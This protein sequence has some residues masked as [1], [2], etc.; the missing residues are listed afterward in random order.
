MLGFTGQRPRCGEITPDRIEYMA[1][2]LSEERPLVPHLV[3]GLSMGGMIG[4]EWGAVAHTGSK[5]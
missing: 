4:A 1:A 5:V 3:V 2:R